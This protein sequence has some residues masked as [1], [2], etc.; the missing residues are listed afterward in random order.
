[1]S[2]L[3]QA[4]MR[5]DVEGTRRHLHEAL[6]RGFNGMTA[7]MHAAENGHS[8]CVKLLLDKEGREQDRNGWTALMFAA[9]R[10]HIECVRLLQREATLRT[11]RKTDETLPGSTALIIAARYGRAEC[12]RLLVGRE[13]GMQ[14]NL[15]HTALMV[16][17]SK[18]FSAIVSML[19]AREARLVDNNGWTALMHAAYWNHLSCVKLL[20]RETGIQSTKEVDSCPTGATALMISAI[21][22]CANVASLLFPHER[23]MVDAHN[24]NALWHASHNALNRKG[25][26]ITAGHPVLITLLQ[27]EP[28]SP[29]SIPNT[30][31]KSL[32]DCA[33]KGDV[34]GVLQCL[35]EAGQHD[36]KGNTALMRAAMGGYETICKILIDREQ[37]SINEDGWSALMFAARYGH[38]ECAR[39]LIS[40][41]SI[42]SSRHITDSTFNFPQGIT[43]LMLAAKFGY[44]EIV[45]LLDP[46]EHTL[47]DSEGN[48]ALWYAENAQGLDDEVRKAIIVA[49]SAEQDAGPLEEVETSSNDFPRVWTFDGI[50]YVLKTD[51]DAYATVSEAEKKLAAVTASMKGIDTPTQSTTEHSLER[52]REVRQL[53]D[54]VAELQAENEALRTAVRSNIPVKQEES[55]LIPF[56]TGLES[57]LN[58]LH[59]LKEQTLVMRRAVAGEDKLTP[60]VD[61]AYNG[62]FALI[63]DLRRDIAASL[64]V[65]AAMTLSAGAQ[66][67]TNSQK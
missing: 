18:N 52:A 63:R 16:A 13:G 54:Q 4:A 27:N 64:Q 1:M 40:E 8:E 41:A 9:R 32:L 33:A 59:R 45:L 44:L 61:D 22:N 2:E 5:G 3:I 47:V 65:L 50:E 6:S 10:N 37:G 57:S 53:L 11:S 26:H 46:H 58:T 25:E 62:V 49:L 31:S 48:G 42:Q 7:L 15:N 38:L 28:T 60:A 23:G 20:L 12:I 30:L 29:S 55:I 21:R 14:D 19:V 43:A 35:S 34:Q 66:D 39:C 24:H 56:R 67:A 51:W 36:S 17:A